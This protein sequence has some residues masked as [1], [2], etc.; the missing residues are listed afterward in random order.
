MYTRPT[1][2]APHSGHLVAVSL[3]TKNLTNVPPGRHA[4][5]TVGMLDPHLTHIAVTIYGF[6]KPVPFA[7]ATLSLGFPPKSIFL[8]VLPPI[9]FSPAYRI[10]HKR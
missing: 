3:P 6:G 1:T 4:V 2:T 9:S 7:P 5:L 10:L 8:Q